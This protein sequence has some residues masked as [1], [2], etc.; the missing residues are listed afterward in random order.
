MKDW[1]EG[2]TTVIS[3]HKRELLA[4]TERAI[5]LKDGRVA[6]DGDLMQILNSARANSV[7]TRP[8]QAVT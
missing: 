4:L 2:R 1:L 7:K 6:R 8:V 5:V 3:T